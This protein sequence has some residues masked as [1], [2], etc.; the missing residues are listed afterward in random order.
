MWV[1]A[2]QARK[3]RKEMSE[4]PDFA[5]PRAQQLMKARMESA[6]QEQPPAPASDGK[7]KQTVLSPAYQ[8]AGAPRKAVDGAKDSRAKKK[9][10]TFDPVRERW[11]SDQR[12]HVMTLNPGD[13][14]EAKWIREGLK[15]MRD[16]ETAFAHR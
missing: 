3:V 16:W 15:L 8:R 11:V 2:L 10:K 12:P 5:P 7:L 9:L 6:N 4:F 13:G 14:D 1:F